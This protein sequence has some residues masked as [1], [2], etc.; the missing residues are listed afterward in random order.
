MDGIGII[1]LL[2]F[3]APIVALAIFSGYWFFKVKNDK[4]ARPGGNSPTT[5]KIIFVIKNSVLVILAGLVI[6]LLYYIFRI[7]YMLYQ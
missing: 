1:I 3:F 6:V 2:L 7:I 5:N 4:N